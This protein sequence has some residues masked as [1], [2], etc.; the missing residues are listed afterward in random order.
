M[1]AEVESPK[2]FNKAPPNERI[3]TSSHANSAVGV[4]EWSVSPS[5]R[6][7]PREPSPHMI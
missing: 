2:R 6:F 5:I 3:Y 4:S 7:I 1:T